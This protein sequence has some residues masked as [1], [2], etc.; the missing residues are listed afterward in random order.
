MMGELFG[1]DVME[2][3]SQVSS[4]FRHAVVMIITEVY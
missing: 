1:A 3:S 2:K 4:E